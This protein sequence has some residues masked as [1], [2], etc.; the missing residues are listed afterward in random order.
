[1]DLF[2][3]NRLYS[4]WSLRPWLVMKR[5]GVPFRTTE[6]DIYSPEGLAAMKLLSPSG[7]VPFLQ[8]DAEVIWDSLAIAEWCAERFP[9]AGLWP[10]DAMARAQA[11]AATCEM[12]GGFQALRH[13]CATGRG[14]TMVGPD[15][16]DPP[17]DPAALADIARVVELW[18]DLKGRFGAAGPYL[19]GD[20]CIADA[21]FTP[22][23]ARFRHYQVDLAG[24]GD[25]DGVAASYRDVLLNQP[26]FQ[27]WS[28]AAMD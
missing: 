21:F 5:C 28:K 20:W 25:G 19:F 2:I 7:F 11:R 6:L 17:T 12:H 27:E 14:H 8:V 26:D 1:M 23:A 3:G 13:H 24:A 22:V 10:K 9:E 4:T 16:S 18:C 15:R